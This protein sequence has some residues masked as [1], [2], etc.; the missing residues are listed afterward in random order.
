[1]YEKDNN[2]TRN[3]VLLLCLASL[4]YY[5]LFIWNVLAANVNTIVMATIG[6]KANAIDSNVT[7]AGFTFGNPIYVETDN[8][9]TGHE[10]VSHGSYYTSEMKFIGNG[11]LKGQKTSVIGKGSLTQ[12]WYPVS[13]LTFRYI[14]GEGVITT[15]NGLNL[16][17]TFQERGHD[18]DDGT[19]LR[20]VIIFS[21]RT[22]MMLGSQDIPS[23]IK[24]FLNP[25]AGPPALGIL[26]DDIT[27]GHR[28]IKVWLWE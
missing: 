2:V 23:P 25:P 3:I 16:T 28:T 24:K 1:M 9:I 22:A 15:K 12:P 11:T 8:L 20:G 21:N 4:I 13:G 10:S 26:E 27:A 14:Q 7:S 6:T 5:S 18:G 19:K 17:Y